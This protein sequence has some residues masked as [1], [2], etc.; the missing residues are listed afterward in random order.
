LF[1]ENNLT[2]H[3]EFIFKCQI[4]VYPQEICIIKVFF[5]LRLLCDVALHIYV[6]YFFSHQ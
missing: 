2:L 6:I 3:Y 5:L 4:Y 1:E